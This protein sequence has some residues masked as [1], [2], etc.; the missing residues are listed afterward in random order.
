MPAISG[1]FR[2]GALLGALPLLSSCGGSDCWD[3]G[4]PSAPVYPTE[5][6]YGLVAGNFNGNSHT[7]VIGTST[8]MYRQAGNAGYLKSYLSTGAGTFAAPVLAADGN[9]P[10]SGAANARCSASS[11]SRRMARLTFACGSSSKPWKARGYT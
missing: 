11:R 8:V 2:C 5:V 3:C 4:H 7:S 6:A 1:F 9:D 10:L